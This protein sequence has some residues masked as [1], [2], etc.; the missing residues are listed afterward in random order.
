[1]D[2][3]F[4]PDVVIYLKWDKLRG[5]SPT[6][7]GDRSIYF[8]AIDLIHNLCEEKSSFIALKKGLGKFKVFNHEYY[9][10]TCLKTH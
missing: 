5:F 9:E 1:M 2:L 4:I 6:I 10:D 7:W 3:D 8:N